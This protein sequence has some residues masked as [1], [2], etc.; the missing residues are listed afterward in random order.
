MVYYPYH[1]RGEIGMLGIVDVG[2]RLRAVYGA[3]ILDFCLDQGICFDWYGGVS[4]EAGNLIS[5]L[6]GQRGR[7]HRFYTRYSSR[8]NRLY[9][10]GY[11]DATRL[12]RWLE[13]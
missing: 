12:S 13:G 11:A 5:F 7:N 1:N 10:S 3:G 8:L 9:Q 4:A 6:A 2:G